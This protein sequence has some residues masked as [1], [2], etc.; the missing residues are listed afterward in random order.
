[1]SQERYQAKRA[2]TLNAG[3]PLGGVGTGCFEMG[4]DGRLRNLT[5]NN[6]RTSD[7]RIPVTP[8]SFIAVRAARRGSVSAR[9]LQADS[10]VPFTEAGISPVYVPV[11]Q[12]AWRG[13]YPKAEYQIN[14]PSFPLAVK[15]QGFSPV[16]PYDVDASTLPVAFFHLEVTNTTDQMI[17]ASVLFNWENL[18]GCTRQKWPESRGPIT[19]LYPEESESVSPKEE[20]ELEEE[21]CGPV[22]LLFG[23]LKS[24]DHNAEGNYCLLAARHPDQHITV[25]Q[26]DA[27]DPEAI[28][29]FWRQ[30]HDEG[31]LDNQTRDV[32]SAH[33]GAVCSSFNIQPKQTMTSLFVFS[34]FC[35]RFVVDGTEQ[36][37]AYAVRF[38][39]AQAVAYRALK[40]H[41]YFLRAVDGWH[42]RFLTSSLPRWF[43][44]MLINCSYAF[45]TNTLLTK[46]GQFAMFETPEDPRT[47]VLDRRLHTSLATLLFFPHLA[48]NELEQFANAEN[49][50]L[51]G[52]LYRCLGFMS[53]SSPTEDD[54]KGELLDLNAKLIL[55]AYRDLCL[56][57]RIAELRKI[58][59]RLKQ[60]LLYIISKD[61]NGDAL[62]EARGFR[63][64]Y[65]YWTFYG[66]DSYSGGLWLTALRAY[67][68]MARTVGNKPEMKWTDELFE[69]ASA[70]FDKRLWNTGKGYY[71]FHDNK[72]N[73]AR[74]GEPVAH[75]CAS[76]QLAGQWY[77][78]LLGLGPILPI[79]HV[80]EALQ[81]IY[82]VHEKGAPVTS[83]PTFHA[84]SYA[85]TE[86]CHGD[87]DRGLFSVQKMY[88][89]LHVKH[90]RTFNHPLCWNLRED[91]ESGWGTDRHMSSLGFW[92]VLFAL[93]GFVLNVAQGEL[94]LRPHL[95][96]GVHMLDAP[97]FTPMCFGRMKFEEGVIDEEYQ[98]LARVS[99]D[100]PIQIQIMV[101]RVP[102]AV[103]EVSVTATGPEGCTDLSHDLGFEDDERLLAIEFAHPLTLTEPLEIRLKQTKGKKVTLQ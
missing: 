12:M 74:E 87:V 3:V 16:I 67:S 70:S 58:L 101:L 64:T 14:H 66:I 24:F 17:D 54:D 72:D 45:S 1:M 77:A 84:T 62:P 9:I 83:W 100:S 22:G 75:G 69:R 82:H 26:W 51:P 33:C 59:P 89:T 30:F 7:A 92:H 53:V 31:T 73:V 68:E 38:P 78:D 6:N 52:K 40:H 94:W 63:T 39:T 86:I 48:I 43:S 61:I 28:A 99:F 44:R 76:G 60:A 29:E 95:P 37:N 10:D 81:T 41:Q 25:T 21:S 55:M 88:K 32:E 47:G 50:E 36:G 93:Q 79:K 103:E 80:R 102:V 8:A 15:W 5:I 18:S 98:Q 91:R 20:G 85:C 42:R 34:W 71:Y 19:P 46:D 90:G 97:L 65:D 57:G 96:R 2:A 35:P 11:E 4:R 56:T 49:S 13:L 23:K 27:S